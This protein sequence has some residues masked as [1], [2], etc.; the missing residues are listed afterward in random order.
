[1]KKY[2]FQSER[3]GFRTWSE[4]DLEAIFQ[5]DSDPE[6]MH[7]F[8]K[9][10]TLEESQKRI[11]KMNQTFQKEGFC[12]FA[13]DF[14]ASGELAGTIGLGRKDFEASFTP[15]IDIGWRLAKKYWN[16]GLASEGALACIGYARQLGLKEIYSYA[17][18]ANQASL[19][20]MRKIGMK[21]IEEFEHPELLN[22]PR[23]QPFSLFKIS[24][25]SSI[26]GDLV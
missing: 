24:L 10:F 21:F 3:L 6:I 13:V 18:T 26:G 22:Q 20:V 7:F 19:Q 14:L 12:Y 16:Q 23:L 17:T 11:Q 1:M 4:S 25:D 2:I 15:C 5:I 9:P 8:E